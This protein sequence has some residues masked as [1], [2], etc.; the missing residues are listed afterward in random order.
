MLNA[1]N[2]ISPV[3]RQMHS[4]MR[5]ATAHVGCL[6]Y[7]RFYACACASLADVQK[8]HMHVNVI[9]H[10]ALPR[11]EDVTKI[12]VNGGMIYYQSVEALFFTCRR[13]DFGSFRSDI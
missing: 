4:H 10:R 13:H 6:P 1:V 7:G 5:K 9:Y 2:T 8:I 11:L 12:V 3:R